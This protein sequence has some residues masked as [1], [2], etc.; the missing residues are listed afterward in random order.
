ML[1]M[2]HDASQRRKTIWNPRRGRHRGRNVG[3]VGLWEVVVPVVS[4]V[5]TGG[6]AIWSKVIDARTKREDRQ[7]ARALDYEGRVWKAKSDALRNLISA[8][9]AVKQRAGIYISEPNPEDQVYNRARLAQALSN[10]KNEIGGE[11]G[12]S[13]ITAYAAERVRDVVDEMLNLIGERLTPHR[14][15]LFMLNNAE[16]QLELLGLMQKDQVSE[17][18][19]IDRRE[20]EQRRT[21]AILAIGDKVDIDVDA[22]A[23]LCNRIIDVARQDIQGRY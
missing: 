20:Q 21:K 1:P 23:K 14:V 5:V 7:H 22:V 18:D 11:E 2:V 4:V 9:R 3:G 17:A 12:V 16:T 19:Q 15:E 8:C 6:V 10:F 13:E